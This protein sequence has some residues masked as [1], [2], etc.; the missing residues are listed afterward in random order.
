MLT[1]YR[2]HKKNCTHRTEGREYR[3]CLCP[4]W[5]DGMIGAADVRKS[6]RTR[7]WQKAQD[8]VREWE[9][10]EAEPKATAE[11]MTIQVA[12]DKYLVDAAAPIMPSAHIGQR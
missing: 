10:R 6:L 8:Y 1:I 9:A 5:A 12:K 11:P 3:R 2:R 7:D 4:I